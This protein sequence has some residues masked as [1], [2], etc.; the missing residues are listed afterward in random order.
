[1]IVLLIFVSVRCIFREKSQF[2]VRE[3]QRVIFWFSYIILN[4]RFYS[5]LL[6]LFLL[7]SEVRN[8]CRIWNCVLCFCLF[9]SWSLWKIVFS[10]KFSDWSVSVI[11][12]EWW[13]VLKYLF[14]TNGTPVIHEAFSFSKIGFFSKFPNVLRT[15]S[16]IEGPLSVNLERWCK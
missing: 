5:L 15:L 16:A 3:L 11:F 12:V 7:I 8:T 1:M 14:M 6:S 2:D 10:F 9:L 4:S 13:M